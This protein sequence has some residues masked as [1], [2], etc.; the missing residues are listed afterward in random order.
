MYV[1][2]CFFR[3]RFGGRQIV[4]AL[5]LWLIYSRSICQLYA[6][7]LLKILSY[8]VEIDEFTTHKQFSY[9]LQL[10]AIKCTNRHILPFDL[11]LWRLGKEEEEVEKYNENMCATS[12]YCSLAI[13]YYFVK[14]FLVVAIKWV[15]ICYSY[16]VCVCVKW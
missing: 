11:Q 12:I 16:C 8:L 2:V 1:C 14:L 3:I 6:Y 9:C 13:K 4:L 5:T 7:T 10:S 15:F